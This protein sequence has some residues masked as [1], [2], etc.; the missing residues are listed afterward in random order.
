MNPNLFIPTSALTTSLLL[1]LSRISGSPLPPSPPFDMSAALPRSLPRASTSAT[2][3]SRSIRR[4]LSTAPTVPKLAAFKREPLPRHQPVASSS[5]LD[6]RPPPP[7]LDSSLSPPA[8]PPSNQAS[9]PIPPPDARYVP[10]DIQD[11]LRGYPLFQK[12]RWH[13]L[14]ALFYKNEQLATPSEWTIEDLLSRMRRA[15]KAFVDDQ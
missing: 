6:H 11:F 9:L 7:H 1:S 12:N 13:V 4:S 5:Q 2:C 14:N 8:T 15:P 10:L 3:C